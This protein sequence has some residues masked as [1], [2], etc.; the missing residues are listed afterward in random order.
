MGWLELANGTLSDQFTCV[1]VYGGSLNPKLKLSVFIFQ[2]IRWA[3][4]V[5]TNAL[6]L[7][8]I[9]GLSKCPP[10]KIKIIAIV[11][12]YCIYYKYF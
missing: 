12:S 5:N 1:P 8:F 7:Y 10:Q 2:S 11:A 9:N 6:F 4:I 3:N